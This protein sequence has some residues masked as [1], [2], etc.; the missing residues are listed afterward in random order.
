MQKSTYKKFLSY[1][2]VVGVINDM[3]VY[4]ENI[5]KCTFGK[6][7]SWNL[8]ESSLFGGSH[9]NCLLTLCVVWHDWYDVRYYS[10]KNNQLGGSLQKT[11]VVFWKYIL[12]EK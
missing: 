8:K 7:K 1:N 10:E 9:T 5:T 4:I 3:I 2:Y 11:F 6:I 12:Y